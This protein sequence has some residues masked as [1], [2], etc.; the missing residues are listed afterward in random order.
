MITV[1]GGALGTGRNSRMYFDNV[2]AYNADAIEVDVYK[3]GGV[4]YLSHL[5]SLFLYRR[6]I[7]LAEAF[8]LVKN[9]GMKIN[10]DLKMRGLV[11]EVIELA[12]SLG[13]EDSLIF[14]G[15]V[16][17]EDSAELTCGQAWL[18]RIKGLPYKAKNVEKIKQKLEET[19]N[20]HFAGLNIN[21]HKASDDF[22]AA[23]REHG[24][25]LS[26]FTVDTY[27][28]LTRFLDWEVA[29]VTTNIPIVASAI[30]FRHGGGEKI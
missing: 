19:G 12:Q 4:L 22:L 15:A 1:H 30:R 10:C 27:K 16:R 7:T 28:Q 8:M 24:V 26:V 9:K 29:N 14:T 25:K 17:L 13:A 20:P 21:K 11:R 2:S 6:K 3:R 23:C 18:N 5:P